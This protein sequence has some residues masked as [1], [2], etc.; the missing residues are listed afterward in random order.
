MGHQHCD[1]LTRDEPR[2]DCEA[3]FDGGVPPLVLISLDGFRPE[4]L[5]RTCSYQE[6]GWAASTIKCLS[7]KGISAPFMTPS[8]PTLTFPNHY[9]VVTGLYPE[10]HEIV[11]NMFYDPKLK[12][13]F[14]FKNSDARD[15]KWWLGGE[16]IWS[17]VRK[18][19]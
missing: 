1:F 16:P 3:Y 7:E 17:T 4:Y 12:A 19:V 18:E 9:S 8:Y 6:G 2:E 5:N 13:S 11:G 14:S 15:S 10:S